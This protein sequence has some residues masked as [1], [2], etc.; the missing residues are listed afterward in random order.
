VVASIVESRAGGGDLRARVTKLAL[1]LGVEDQAVRDVDDRLPG[2]VVAQ[3]LEQRVQG[4]EGIAVARARVP[5]QPLGLVRHADLALRDRVHGDALVELGRAHRAAADAVAFDDGADRSGHAAVDADGLADGH[6]QQGIDLLQLHAADLADGVEDRLVIASRRDDRSA[7]RHRD[8]AE[9]IARREVV[10]HAL[11]P[12][13]RGPPIAQAHVV[14]IDDDEDD[15]RRFGDVV[16]AHVRQ[17]PIRRGLGGADGDE[18]EGVD[19]SRLAVDGED[20]V[21]GGETGDRTSVLVHDDRVDRD[22]VDAGAEDGLLGVSGQG[23]DDEHDGEGDPPHGD[24]RRHSTILPASGSGHLACRP[25][26]QIQR[27]GFQYSIELDLRGFVQSH[28]Q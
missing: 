19:R 4:R 18:L 21:V 11:E 12:V 15:A 14:A 17:P 25:R 8:E 20:E 2:V 16:A 22:E 5:D 6:R 28:L 1:D 26:P 27:S 24:Q 3:A 9:A 23:H 13:E 7:A 10:D